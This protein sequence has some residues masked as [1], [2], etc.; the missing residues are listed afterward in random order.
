MA[1]ARNTLSQL[2]RKVAARLAPAQP[3]RPPRQKPGVG[4]RQ[5]VLPRR[6]RHPL[7]AHPAAGRAGD[8]A[9]AIQ[10]E[11]AQAPERHELEPPRVQRVVVGAAAPAA[12]APGPVA[13]VRVD[14]NLEPE[15]G[16]LPAQPRRAIHEPTM[17]L[18]PIQDSL[19]LHPAVASEP[20]GLV[21]QPPWSQGRGGMRCADRGP[22][23]SCRRRGRTRPPRLGKRCA[24]PT[25][26]YKASHQ[27]NHPRHTPTET[28]RKPRPPLQG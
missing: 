28:E 7:D 17:F 5:L 20:S 27:P 18:N 6:P 25:S 8:P 4:G 2:V 26:F 9:H 24:F 13:P 19:D 11:D 23:G 1:T 22:C 15:G 14:L 10:E 21:Y 12:A 3:L 16:P